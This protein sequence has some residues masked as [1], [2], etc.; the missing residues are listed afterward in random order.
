MTNDLTVTLAAT[1]QAIR[2]Q[3]RSVL[4]DIDIY[5]AARQSLR[6]KLADHVLALKTYRDQLIADG[7]ATQA[8]SELGDQIKRLEDLIADVPGGALT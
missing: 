6:A 4:Q 2:A 8:A 7:T 3:A 5:I 1:I